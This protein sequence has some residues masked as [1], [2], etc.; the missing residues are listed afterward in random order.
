MQEKFIQVGIV[1]PM[2]PAP[3]LQP[4]RDSHI[5][6]LPTASGL[7]SCSAHL[8][9]RLEARGLSARAYSLSSVITVS[10]HRADFS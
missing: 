8:E 5:V 3:T 10:A 6:E 7:S 1:A 4:L 2:A 9:A